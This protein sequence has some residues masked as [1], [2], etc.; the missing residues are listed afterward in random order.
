MDF[1]YGGLREKYRTDG[2]REATWQEK[3]SLH[4]SHFLSFHGTFLYP[5]SF[6][7]A[8]FSTFARKKLLIVL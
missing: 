4:N 6:S 2:P 7:S 5:T 3:D 8:S 1:L